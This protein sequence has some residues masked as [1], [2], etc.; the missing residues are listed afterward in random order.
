MHFIIFLFTVPSST[1]YRELIPER[2]MEVEMRLGS[3]RID[4]RDWRGLAEKLGFTEKDV[5]HFIKTCDTA[6]PVQRMLETWSRNDA[7]TLGALVTALHLIN[8]IDVVDQIPVCTY[9]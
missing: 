9:T 4:R 2:R 1:L 6:L 5:M 8:R 7:A 3:T